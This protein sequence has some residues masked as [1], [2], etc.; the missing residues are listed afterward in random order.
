MV[1]RL[2]GRRELCTSI[3]YPSS[4]SNFH[5]ARENERSEDVL[6]VE[7]SVIRSNSSSNDLLGRRSTGIRSNCINPNDR[8]MRAMLKL[9][10]L[11][12]CYTTIRLCKSR[13]LPAITD[14]IPAGIP[15]TPI[16][17]RRI[18]AVFTRTPRDSCHP[19]SHARPCRPQLQTITHSDIDLY[20]AV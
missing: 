12:F 3:E 20:G 19:N 6:V 1:T 10:V 17:L 11:D 5:P 15:M 13:G 7:T 2:N 16:V 14:S 8:K 4:S 18:P 9:K